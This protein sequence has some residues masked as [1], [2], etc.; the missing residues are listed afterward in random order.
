MNKTLVLLAAYNG[1][2]WLEDQVKTI[3]D[4]N[5]KPYI[6]IGDDNSSDLSIQNLPYDVNVKVIFHNSDNSGSANNFFNLIRIANIA[7]Y[8][9]IA[10]SDQDDIWDT[11][12]LTTAIQM[13]N[14][15][16]A[17]AYSSNVTAFWPDG[18]TFLINKAQ[19]Q[20]D[21]DY[22]FESA[23]PGCTFVLT[24]KLALHLQTFLI[25]N[26]QACKNVSL[27][28]WFIYA[29]ARTKG[30]KWVIDKHPHMQYRQ[31]EKN[32][33]G[34][35]VGLKAKLTRWHKLRAG[36]LK[37]QAILLA[38]IIGY[39]DSWVIKRLRRNNLIDK[40]VLIINISKFRRKFTDRLAL[41]LSFIVGV[42]K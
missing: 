5:I 11:D 23:G 33:I 42:K 34:A 27:H 40:L 25:K 15:A 18:K 35:N 36:W 4:Q 8:Q 6:I 3:H 32:V 16:N 14:V 10:L 37:T 38:D 1:K 29:F 13:L 19:P 9:F 30:Y 20:L 12:K 39:S 41:A 7:E 26:Q 21:F 31:H 17:D 2:P 24:K 28:D 22:I